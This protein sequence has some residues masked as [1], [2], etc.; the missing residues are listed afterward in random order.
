MEATDNNRAESHL[1]SFLRGVSE[2]GVPLRTRSDKG[3]ENVDIARFMIEVRGT[4][5]RSHICGRSVHNQRSG[6]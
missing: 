1:K 4:G 5:R 3:G 6:A 2:F